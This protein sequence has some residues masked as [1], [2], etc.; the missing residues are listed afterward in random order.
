MYKPFLIIGGYGTVGS[1][2]ISIL[3]EFL[4]ELPIVIAGRDEEKACTSAAMYNNT[5]G[6]AVDTKRL[7]LGID[8][9]LKFS[10]IAVLTNDL[11]TCPAQY[12]IAHN[13]PYTSIATQLNHIAPKLVLCLN[14]PSSRVLIQDTSFA[15]VLTC[16]GI[17]FSSNFQKVEL[18][19]VA[20]LMD[21]N[22]L[23]GPAS[24]TDSDAFSV[25]EAGLLLE[26]S[27]W[28]VPRDGK[29][30]REYTLEDGFT[31]TGM[32]FPGFDAP[33]LA[34]ST[35]AT[36]VR[37]DF[38]LGQSQGSRHRK[39]PSVDVIYEFD[40][41]LPNGESGSLK[42]QMSHPKGQAFMT[43]VGVAVGIESLLLDEESPGIYLTSRKIST[44]LMIS[45]LIQSGVSFHQFE[46]PL[47]S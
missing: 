3:N 26:D 18:I 32:S 27:Q 5:T 40:G 8:T 21:E 36:T 28:K 20:T 42:F 9:K 4:P 43:A 10:G 11:S 29:E 46:S 39:T 14:N 35:G 37:V 6:I 41:I 38:A 33:E 19:R 1:H 30:F 13:I 24:R 22:D 7:D 31:F 2:L 44:E 16:A 34:C 25:K 15:G 45:R 17:Y 23:G 47:L 12:A